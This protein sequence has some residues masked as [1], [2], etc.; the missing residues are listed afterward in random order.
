TSNFNALQN[1]I[2]GGNFQTC[3]VGV[4]V[5]KGSVPLIASVGFQQSNSCDIWLEN[6]AHDTITVDSCRSE[7]RHFF[8]VTHGNPHF[9]VR[10][11]SHIDAANTE[12]DF[13]NVNGSSTGVVESSVSVTGRMVLSE[14]CRVRVAY[15]SFGR[16]DWINVGKRGADM[17]I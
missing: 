11:C 1:T 15:S 6:S 9:N 13:V 16:S 12:G 7:S 2:I 10:G 4:W 5:A 14:D 17:Q 8:K 3:G